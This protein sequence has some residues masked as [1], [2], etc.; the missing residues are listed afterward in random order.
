VLA[1]AYENG[2]IA[3]RLTVFALLIAGGVALIHRLRG[4]RSPAVNVVGVVLMAVAALAVLTGHG[5]VAT[6]PAATKT[7]DAAYLDQARR[8]MIAGCTDQGS[9]RAYCECFAEQMLERNGHDVA[10]LRKTEA[11]LS[12]MRA[13]SSPP[14]ILVQASQACAEPA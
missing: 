14:A 4:R 1:T 12:R 9:A 13:G 3:G 6:V 7:P 5:G 10:R 8:D 2:Q 11:E